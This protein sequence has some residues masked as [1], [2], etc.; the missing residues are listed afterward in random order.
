MK[1]I[2]AVLDELEDAGR[3]CEPISV[4]DVVEEI[5][6]RSFAILLMV[7]ALSMVSPISTIPGLPT[8]SASLIGLVA[9]Q[10]LAGREA[11]GLLA[12]PEP[13]F[14]QASPGR[15]VPAPAGDLA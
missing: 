1:P 2:S 8:L 5:G 7:P 3:E 10:M 15:E 6:G 13:R 11:A 4:S 14:R 9:N 12:S